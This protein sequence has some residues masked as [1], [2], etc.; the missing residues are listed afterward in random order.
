MN[1]KAPDDRGFVFELTEVDGRRV[2]YARHHPEF[3]PIVADWTTADLRR[4]IAGGRKQLLAR[5]I[6][7]HK[8]ADL[9]VLDTTGGMGRD[10]FTLAALG[11]QVALVE[12]QPLVARLLE[13]ALARAPREIAARMQVHAGDAREHLQGR[14]WDAIYL[15]PIYPGHDRDAR[16]K[17]EMQVLRELSGGDLDAGDLLAAAIAVKPGRVVVK[18]PRSAPTLGE[19]A[20]SFAL[21]GTQAR[22]DVYLPLAGP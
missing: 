17:K 21:S 11:A 3:G 13:D 4:R 22:F 19:R 7:L 16:S 14:Q 18:R 6:G 12:R 8:R 2:L 5:A 9:V 15:D 1:A 10:A 20:P